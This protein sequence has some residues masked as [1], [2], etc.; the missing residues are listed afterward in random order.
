MLEFD[1]AGEKSRK[2][3]KGVKSPTFIQ[4][5]Q[6]NSLKVWTKCEKVYLNVQM[7]SK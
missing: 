5:L 6:N 7:F 4:M 1:W 2:F 3:F